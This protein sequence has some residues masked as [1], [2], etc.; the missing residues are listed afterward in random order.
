MMSSKTFE[1][2]SE[3]TREEKHARIRELARQRGV[4]P[5]ERIEDLQ[6]DFWPE[7]ESTD[8]FLEWLYASRREDK[9]RSIP[10]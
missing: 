6:G 10:E 9:A 2:I 8:D 5:I 3:M 1:E 4:K 7:E